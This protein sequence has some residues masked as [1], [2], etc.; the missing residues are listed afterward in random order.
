MSDPINPAYYADGEIECIDAIHAAL[1]DIG[2]VAYCR[3]NQIKYAWRAG[4][5]GSAAEDMRKAE[6]YAKK[7]ADTLSGS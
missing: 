6:W 7:A 1:G 3:G 4:K 5:K 2:F